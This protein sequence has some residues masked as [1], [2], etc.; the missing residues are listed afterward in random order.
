MHTLF[1]LEDIYGLHFEKSGKNYRLV[2]SQS[3]NHQNNERFHG[4]KTAPSHP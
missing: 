3:E 1:E 4:F 2:F